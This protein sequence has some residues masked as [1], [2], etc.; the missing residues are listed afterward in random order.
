MNCICQN[1]C[2][3]SVGD[4]IE[5]KVSANVFTTS[6]GIDVAKGEIYKFSSFGEWIDAGFP[7]T[8]ANGFH[9]N[10]PVLMLGRIL[11]RM[12]LKNY[13]MLCGSIKKAHHFPIGT[14]LIRKMNASG[15]LNLYPNDAR[16]FYNNNKGEMRV[17]VTRIK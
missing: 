15:P 8:D 10:N 12:P 9:S 2:K 5:I 11:K 16:F 7:A 13:M 1:P 17:L 4:S 6:G 14:S 3:L